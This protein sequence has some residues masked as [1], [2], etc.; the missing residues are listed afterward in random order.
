MN[1]LNLG[2]AIVAAVAGWSSFAAAE[3][4]CEGEVMFQCATDT[5]DFREQITVCTSGESYSLTRHTLAT[6]EPYYDTPLIADANTTWFAWEE[7]D[8]AR[9]ELGFWSTDLG[10]PI[11]LHVHLPWDDVS[12][13]V[14]EDQPA[15]MW[16]QS[17]H[18]RQ[19]VDQTFCQSDT[20]YAAPEALW[21]AQQERGPIA[22]FFS[23]DVVTPQAATVGVA[24]VTG[25][26][27]GAEGLPVFA[28][29]RPGAAT[30]VWW[31]LQPGEDVDVIARSGD[32]LAVALPTNGISGCMIRPEHLGHPYT[33]PCATGWV[34]ATYLERIQ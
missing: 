29:A 4:V 18:W 2:A 25:R 21:P 16:L 27:E 6:G 23:Q 30:P 13:T 31:M 24:R 22:V 28:S 26:P 8:H 7:G 1:R 20:V 12:E 3:A 5:S 32:F 17:P 9:M 14:L 15:D 10:E 11:T 19:Q 33:G 34:D